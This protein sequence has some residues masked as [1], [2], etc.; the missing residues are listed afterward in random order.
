[1][2]DRAAT[3][4]LLTLIGALIPSALGWACLASY[5]AGGIISI[6]AA[7]IASLEEDDHGL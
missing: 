1:M 3:A 5:C 7:V 4:A 6:A 2:S